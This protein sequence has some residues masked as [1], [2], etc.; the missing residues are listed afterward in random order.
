MAAWVKG[1]GSEGYLWRVTNLS[2][3]CPGLPATPEPVCHP[4]SY[5]TA[6]CFWLR[7][8]LC[9]PPRQPTRVWFSNLAW[10]GS[11]C[12][13]CSYSHMEPSL[14]PLLVSPAPSSLLFSHTGRNRYHWLGGLNNKRLFSHSCE[15]WKSK[16]K[17]L[18]G[19]VSSEACLLGL[20][21]AVLLLPLHVVVLCA[22]GP[23]VPFVC[24]ISYFYKD[25]GQSGLGPTLK[26][27]FN[28]IASLKTYF[29]MQLH[30]EGLGIETSTCEF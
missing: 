13:H 5:V 25:T 16:I 8:L 15:G 1:R 21:M 23:P 12:S 7:S 17:V 11:N 2:V 20:E 4:L 24:P 18:A 6:G 27:S 3:H 28:L 30:S 22:R 14:G 29:Q 9:V 26:A 10:S 19:L